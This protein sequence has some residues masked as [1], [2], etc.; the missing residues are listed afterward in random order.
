VSALN[1][2]EVRYG[3][4]DASRP[5]KLVRIRNGIAVAVLGLYKTERG[6][7]RALARRA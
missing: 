5:W 7:K 3:T 6:A 4:I 2:Y 1:G